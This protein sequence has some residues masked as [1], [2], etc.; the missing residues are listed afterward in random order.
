MKV[1]LAQIADRVG[2]SRISVSRALRNGPKV[3]PEVR[4]KILAAAR[5][6]GWRPDPRLSRAMS[7]L[8]VSA[9]RVSTA[10][11]IVLVWP[12][13]N[14]E[15]I[16][17]HPALRLLRSGARSRADAQGFAFEEVFFSTCGL[18]PQRLSQV[19][20]A[21]GVAG[22]IAGPVSFHDHLRLPLD[23]SRFSAIAVGVG[24]AE[25]RLSRVHNDHHHTM[26]EC[27]RRLASA[28]GR[29]IALALYPETAERL[30]GLLDGAF[31]ARH[32]LGREEAARLLHI[33]DDDRGPAMAAWLETARPDHV[34]G[35]QPDDTWLAP[36]RALL[37]PRSRRS[38]RYATF[39]WL[40]TSP[41]TP[42]MNQC[43]DRIGAAAVD[44]VIAQYH[45]N[46]RAFST[47]PRH[48]L[49]QGEWIKPSPRR[50]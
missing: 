22:L 32:P 49:T 25:P 24:L 42:G 9:L 38:F 8:R 17:R 41:G 28:G 5:S 47:R 30:D 43:F 16:G 50:T 14:E 3:A 13:G 26:A 11:T 34:L 40:E 27:L 37:P 35:E 2:C 12:D 44:A 21:R 4:R 46:E 18:R 36:A 23:W 10:E 33:V 31:L 1:S 45:R 6:L 48:I 19:L 15:T 20:Y 39:N 29:R 7:E